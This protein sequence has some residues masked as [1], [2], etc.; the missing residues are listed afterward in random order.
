MM[1]RRVRPV[2]IPALLVIIAAGAGAWWWFRTPAFAL[3]ARVDRNVLLITID[4]LRGDTLGSYGGRAATP[5]LDRLASHGARFTFA[6]AHAVL[7]LPSHA[8][9]LTG[10]YPYEHGIRD[11]S[12]FRVRAG[13]A[14]LASRLKPLGFATAAFVSAYPLDQRFGL[15]AGF[16]TYDD[17]FSEVGRTTDLVVPERRADATVASALEW[18]GRQ[19]GK[20]FG[21]VH[22]FDPHAPY[23]PPPDWQAK[24]PADAY[25]AEVAWTDFALGPLIEKVAAAARPTLVVVTADHGEGLG[26]HDELTHGIFAYESTLHVPLVIAELGS[27]LG[28]RRGITIT[29]PVRHVDLAPTVLEAAGMPDVNGVSG[30]SLVGVIARGGGDDRPSY[31]ESMMPTLARGWA[32]LRGVLVSREKYIDL[33]IPELYDLATDARELQNVAAV[34]ADRTPVLQAALRGFDVAPPGRPAQETAAARERLRALG[35]TGGSPAPA[36]ERYTDA[37]DPKR[38]IELDRMLHRARELFQAGQRAE[39]VKMYQAVISRRP[40][41][42]DAYRNLSF[43][44][45][46]SGRPAQAIAALEMALTHGVLQRDIQVKLGTYLVEVGAAAKAIP[47]LEALPRDDAE[48]LNALG[49]AYASAGRPADAMR[50]FRRALEFDP[51]SGLAHQNIGTLHLQAGDLKAAEAELRQA[52]EID[53]TVSG[54][55]TT[56]GVVLVKTGRGS[57]AVDSWTRAVE[58]EPTE[59]DALYNLTIELLAQGRIDDARKFGDRYLASAPPALYARDLAYLRKLLGR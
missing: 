39:A 24:Y 59:F 4:T 56:L 44:L 29:S 53:P 11:N 16:D 2:A 3:A 15:N 38:L 47:L 20:W 51:T 9:I 37:D 23:T 14:T 49:I 50:M 58:L 45:W 21:W 35:Y 1:A 10:R 55:L 17:R 34:R 31:F 12:G 46:Q 54:A 32:P 30:A 33:P 6:H 36:R 42:A 26:D 5:N 43:V 28:A 40:D 57:E 48:A 13:E 52:L 8:S 18:I 22:V 25:A 41:T 27:G 19:S 7:T